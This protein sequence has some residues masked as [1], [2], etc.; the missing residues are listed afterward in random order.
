MKIYLRDWL[1][2]LYLGSGIFAAMLLFLLLFL[3][4]LQMSSRWFNITIP[5][6]ANYAGYCMGGVSFF[7]LAYGI[8]KGSHIRVTLV[9]RHCGAYTKIIEIFAVGISALV[10]AAFAFHAI[11]SNFAS[12][13][14]GEVSQAQDATFIWIPQL[15]MSMGACIFF[16]AMLDI[17]VSLLLPDSERP[18]ALDAAPE[19]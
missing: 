10:A 4:L 16:V 13:H 11:K 19:E 12:Y 18:L 2:R 3:V 7:G 17:F 6:L 5:G 8:S 1:D 14:F 15:S 9:V